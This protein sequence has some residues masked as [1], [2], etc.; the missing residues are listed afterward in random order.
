MIEL[1]LFLF[2]YICLYNFDIHRASTD[3]HQAVFCYL[4]LYI[5]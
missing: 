3:H 1:I 4:A 5:L 2:M